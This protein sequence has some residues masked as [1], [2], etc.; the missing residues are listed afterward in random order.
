MIAKVLE[1]LS[2]N[3]IEVLIKALTKLN[4]WFRSL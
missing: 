3:E 2:E 1:G 4:K